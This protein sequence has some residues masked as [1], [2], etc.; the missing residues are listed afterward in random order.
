MTNLWDAYIEQLAK[1]YL[2]DPL[3]VKAII[4]QESGGNPYALRYEPDYDYLFDNSLYSHLLGVTLN[5]EIITQKCSWGLSQMMGGV[6]REL[7]FKGHMGEQFVPETNIAW[8]CKKL[9]KIAPLTSCPSDF[10]AAWNGGLGAINK[11]TGVYSNQTYVNEANAHLQ[12][13]QG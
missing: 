8:T 12:K 6:L 2:L 11:V 13:L 3:L 5:T 9:S 4:I 1:S 10:F 7:G